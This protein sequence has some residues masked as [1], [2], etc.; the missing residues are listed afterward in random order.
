[1]RATLMDSWQ[2]E[3][4]GCEMC[5][6]DNGLIVI[7]GYKP[8]TMRN[9]GG[10]LKS[11]FGLKTLEGPRW[12]QIYDTQKQTNVA[13]FKSQCEHDATI[14]SWSL[15]VKPYLAEGCPTCSCIRVYDLLSR[16][17]I[18]AWDPGVKFRHIVKCTKDITLLVITEGN[19]CFPLEWNEA[20]RKLTPYPSAQPA[21]WRLL[22][23]DPAQPS[24]IGDLCVEEYTS[25]QH[26]MT[27]VFCINGHTISCMQSPKLCKAEEFN[28]LW[29]LNT[30]F[31]KIEGHPLDITHICTDPTGR[32]YGFSDYQNRVIVVDGTTGRITQVI[33]DK[34]MTDCRSLKWLAKEESIVA[35]YDKSHIDIY[36][37]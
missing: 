14:T 4:E 5:V 33:I 31:L 35:L 18:L 28:L 20:E 24:N 9:V 16:R 36:K 17:F 37:V 25:G 26:A 10:W 34:M 13:E 23:I 2:T 7:R 8:G 27:Q 3:L 12:I 6:T 11:M 1:M 22:K 21:T 32:L 29:S 30:N 19:R 15:L